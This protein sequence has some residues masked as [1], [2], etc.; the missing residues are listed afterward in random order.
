[1][2]TIEVTE[3]LIPTDGISA[4][5]RLRMRDNDPAFADAEVIDIYARISQNRGERLEKTD[6]QIVELLRYL[7]GTP[8]RLGKI[9]RDDNR[10]AW[11]RN[12]KRPGWDAVL[13]RMIDGD[14]NGIISTYID[15]VTRQT[16]DV[17]RLIDAVI[18]NELTVVVVT[19]EETYD[20]RDAGSR[21]SLKQEA[22]SA[23]HYSLRVSQKQRDR[24]RWRR[25]DGLGHGGPR[26]FGQPT[27]PKAS[28]E[29]VSAA[30]V[31]SERDA[32]RAAADMYLARKPLKL[33]AED[34][35]AR[36]F[37]KTSGA[38][39]QILLQPRI[40]ALRE[41]A[42]TA[43]GYASRTDVP[44]IVDRATWLR[45]RDRLHA[46]SHGRPPLSGMSVTGGVVTC[47]QCG[48]PLIHRRNGDRLIY[49]CPPRGC[50]GTTIAAPALES[51]LRDRVVEIL[52][53]QAFS[54]Q[55]RHRTEA[56]AATREALSLAQEELATL[57]DQ[58]SKAGMRV[59][60]YAAFARAHRARVE[61]L[62]ASLFA[63]TAAPGSIEYDPRDMPAP[64]DA[65]AA[66]D[67][68]D[69]ADR[70]RLVRRTFAAIVAQPSRGKRLP[71]AQRLT[72]IEHTA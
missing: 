43:T 2:T 21:H 40:A 36:G 52:A 32:I 11:K 9:L 22:L 53:S 66:W 18:D 37:A 33:I 38:I 3:S 24:E 68:G 16:R 49:R 58:C 55:E 50:G 12:G 61:Q 17:E 25:E 28:G 27:G 30:Q 47:A 63:L 29:P 59:E 10:S 6:R 54:D 13:T 26:P 67:D 31:E 34:W 60:E 5:N 42:S 20:L 65:A 15:R 45:L 64:I 35:Q 62:E 23:E 41:D 8:Y 46:A 44:E 69:A 4:Y 19:P 7:T 57:A 39:R 1:M 51:V 56:I 71:A 72:F 48:H 14:S 70:G